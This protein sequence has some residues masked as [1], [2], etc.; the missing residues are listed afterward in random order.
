LFLLSVYRDWGRGEVWIP[1]LPG[2]LSIPI[3]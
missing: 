1:A 2:T 3:A